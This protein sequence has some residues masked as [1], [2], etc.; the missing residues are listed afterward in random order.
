[1]I[2]MEIY[3]VYAKSDSYVGM[4]YQ[5]P[6]K[7]TVSFTEKDDAE[8]FIAANPNP[9]HLYIKK[10]IIQ[11]FETYDEYTEYNQETIREHALSKL[12]A[13]EQKALGLG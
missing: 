12:S 7:K 2:T 10:E 9:E 8:D 1:M 13:A 11:V 3:E 6:D 4:T 5:I